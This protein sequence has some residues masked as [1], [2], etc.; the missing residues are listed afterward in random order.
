MDIQ[1]MHEPG[2][3]P[4][5]IKRS[6]KKKNKKENYENER[7]NYKEKLQKALNFQK[8]K[9]DQKLRGR[10]LTNISASI[11]RNE[12]CPTSNHT[13]PTQNQRV[14]WQTQ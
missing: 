2:V 9:K 7:K 3:G 11:S 8:K 4:V 13:H 12:L 10:I 6:N 1:A 5:Q 14:N